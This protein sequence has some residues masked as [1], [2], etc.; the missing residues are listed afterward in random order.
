[1]TT[2]II[3]ETI[4]DDIASK[5]LGQRVSAP[6]TYTPSILVPVPRIENRVQYEITNNDFVG[7]D[8]WNCYEV[9]FLLNNGFPITCY[10]KLIYPSYTPNIVE[11]KSIKL[12]LNSYNME[13]LGDNEESA[14]KNMSTRVED[15]LALLL[16]CF[17]DEV[18]FILFSS[19]QETNNQPIN[20]QQDYYDLIN[21]VDY[22][23]LSE[24]SAYK[25]DPSLLVETE[26]NRS[27]QVY[28]DSVRSNCRVT[29]QPDY[30]TA[31]IRMTGKTTPTYESLAKYLISFR[32]ESHFHE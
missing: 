28:F 31:Y 10:G 9:S 6:L 16:G 25:E 8:T 7:F 2:E 1:M 21:L 12:Y 19:A 4:T 13:K 15:D 24:V 20:N 29:H 5:V 27:L 30:A 14:K 32:G 17:P 26:E 18:K 22:S 11:S 23:K 3:Q